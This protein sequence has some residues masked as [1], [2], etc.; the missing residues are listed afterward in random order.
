MVL[1]GSTFHMH[2]LNKYSIIIR[3][4]LLDDIRGIGEHIIRYRDA[5]PFSHRQVDVKLKCC[6]VHRSYILRALSG[7][8]ALHDLSRKAA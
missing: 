3:N 1:K 6:Q 4:V 5:E 7:K 8:D 2:V